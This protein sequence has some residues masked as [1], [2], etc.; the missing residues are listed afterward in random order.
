MIDLLYWNN[1]Y[2]WI[3]DFDRMMFDITKSR[4]RKVICR[5]CFG[6]FRTQELFRRHQLFCSRPDFTSTIFTLPPPG[7]L[8]KFKN[9]RFQQRMPFVIYAD[10][11][12]NC[13]PCGT[14]THNTQFYNEQVPCAVGFQLVS[15]IPEL[16]NEPY[17][18]CRGKDCI[19]Q[20]FDAFAR[21][22]ETLY[23]SPF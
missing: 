3:T 13:L 10:C 18:V 19:D 5:K 2:A 16:A 6:H 17:Q 23:G 20:F 12:A 15:T 9:V 22:G 4:T 14:Q 21:F 8:L 11:E 7:T 1:H